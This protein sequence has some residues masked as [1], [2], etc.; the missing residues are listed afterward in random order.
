M[1]ASMPEQCNYLLMPN[2]MF[3]SS[4]DRLAID[5]LI[6]QR[7]HNHPST[8]LSTKM[9]VDDLEK[10]LIMLQIRVLQKTERNLD[11]ESRKLDL[12]LEKD[13]RIQRLTQ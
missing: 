10:Q 9:N 1:K 11:K 7:N 13:S 8:T 6:Q 3:N 2:V 5:R 12:E 4:N